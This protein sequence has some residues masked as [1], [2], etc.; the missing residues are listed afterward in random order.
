MTYYSCFYVVEVLGFRFFG[1]R[2]FYLPT[3]NILNHNTYTMANTK[4][5]GE[6]GSL[7]AS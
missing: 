2:M 3:P 7:F 1:F 5:I 4:Q 6:S